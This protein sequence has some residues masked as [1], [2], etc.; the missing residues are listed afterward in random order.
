M[1]TNF[2]ALTLAFLLAVSSAPAFA[3]ANHDHEG[4]MIP[5]RWTEQKQQQDQSSNS[6]RSKKEGRDIGSVSDTQKAPLESQ[7]VESTPDKSESEKGSQSET[8]QRR[9]FHFVGRLGE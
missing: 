7:K 2:S 3:G 4:P 8:S 5:R 6:S 9:P 1:K